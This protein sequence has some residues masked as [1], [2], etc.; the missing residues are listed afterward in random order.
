MPE[1]KQNRIK[2]EHPK[3]VEIINVLISCSQFMAP[4]Q[5]QEKTDKKLISLMFP[6]PRQS[7]KL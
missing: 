1:V 5:I 7:L 2:L 6:I 4:W 3:D